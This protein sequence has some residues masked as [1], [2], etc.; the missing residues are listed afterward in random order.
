MLLPLILP[1]ICSFPVFF[2][3]AKFIG[4]EDFFSRVKF[5]TNFRF[6]FNCYFKFMKEIR[7]YRFYH[8]YIV[9]LMRTSSSPLLYPLWGVRGLLSWE[10]ILRLIFEVILPIVTRIFNFTHFVTICKLFEGLLGRPLFRFDIF[11]FVTLLFDP[12]IAPC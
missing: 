1:H 12:K 9:V 11:V 3:V 4:C 8:C 2:T 5:M 6:T 7:D 10:L